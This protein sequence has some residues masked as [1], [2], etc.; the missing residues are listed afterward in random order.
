MRGPNEFWFIWQKS[1]E[2]VNKC[3]LFLASNWTKPTLRPALVLSNLKIEARTI[4]LRS[5]SEISRVPYT[6]AALPSTG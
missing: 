2:N 5:V 3:C 1:V 6:L 4:R